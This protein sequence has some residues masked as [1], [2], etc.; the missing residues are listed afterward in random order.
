MR[1]NRAQTNIVTYSCIDVHG[2]RMLWHFLPGYR[3]PVERCEQPDRF[4]ATRTRGQSRTEGDGLAYAY[5]RVGSL[6]WETAWLGVGLRA[7]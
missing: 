6:H 1:N 3:Q 4:V 2:T 5:F 7:D